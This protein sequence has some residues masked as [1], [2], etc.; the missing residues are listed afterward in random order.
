MGLPH[1]RH[2]AFTRSSTPGDAPRTLDRL[3]SDASVV[4][5]LASD[6][7]HP[8]RL[9]AASPKG[10]GSGSA[11]LRAAATVPQRRDEPG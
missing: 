4:P 11:A 1:L 2:A 6:E 9:F 7:R 5:T 8:A 3:G 10:C